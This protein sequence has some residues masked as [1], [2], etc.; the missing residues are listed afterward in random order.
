M[1]LDSKLDCPSW[2]E[3]FKVELGP[4]TSIF[5]KKKFFD[6]HVLIMYN[7]GFIMTFS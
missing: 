2:I 1:R 3:Q 7:N 4:D 5:F 6:E